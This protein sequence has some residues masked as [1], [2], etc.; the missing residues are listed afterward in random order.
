MEKY[1]LF[2]GFGEVNDPVHDFNNVPCWIIR[3]STD[4]QGTNGSASFPNQIF[5]FE[6]CQ[7][8]YSPMA[9]SLF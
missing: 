5:K 3:V 2:G 1:Y 9:I 4:D 7:E 6:R 8:T